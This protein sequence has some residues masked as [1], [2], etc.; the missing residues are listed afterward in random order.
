MSIPRFRI[1]E[2]D[3]IEACLRIQGYSR[4]YITTKSYK[5]IN[6]EDN[7]EYGPSMLKLNQQLI[8]VVKRDCIVR[9]R[10]LFDRLII[11]LKV[12]IKYKNHKI[13]KLVLKVLLKLKY[14]SPKT[15]RI[16]YLELIDDEIY[17]FLVS[18]P[19]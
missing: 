16:S 15:E 3:L 17:C 5:I 12:V 4:F 2:W 8:E 9:S 14:C 6:N 7:Y 19:C 10:E 13:M 11:I 18:S 1:V